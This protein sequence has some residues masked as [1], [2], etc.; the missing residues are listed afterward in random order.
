MRRCFCFVI[1]F[2]LVFIGLVSSISIPSNYRDVQSLSFAQSSHRIHIVGNS[3]WVNFKDAG[4]CSGEGTFTNPYIIK[5]LIIDG[6]G[7]E[8]SISIENST[9]FFK[10]EN[11]TIYNSGEDYNDKALFLNNITNGALIDNNLTNNASGIGLIK[12]FNCTIVGNSLD[13][14]YPYGIVLVGVMIL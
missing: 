10:I 9:V 3:G 11:C 1:L 5:D 4:N 12:S 13:D 8:K 6:G 7:I 2:L 14:N